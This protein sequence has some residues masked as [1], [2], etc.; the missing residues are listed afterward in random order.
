MLGETKHASSIYAESSFT[1][2]NHMLLDRALQQDL[3]LELA[4][5]GRLDQVAVQQ[6]SLAKHP[7]L[8]MHLVYLEQEG[9]VKN[10]STRTMDDGKTKVLSSA[11]TNEGMN[12]LAGDGGISAILKVVTVR[13]HEDT[14]AQL[15]E[16]HLQQVA[17]DQPDKAGFLDQLRSLPADAI[18]HVTLDLLAKGV[19][20]LPATLPLLQTWLLQAAQNVR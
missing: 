13:L 15:L 11:I 12:F 18:K 4:Q 14:L 19:A 1:R 20:Q 9:L 3:L 6:L 16:H 17:A 2:G 10:I 8:S 7:D 5:L